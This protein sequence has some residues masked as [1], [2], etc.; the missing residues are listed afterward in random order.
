MANEFKTFTQRDIDDTS[1]TLY[2]C[3]S[4]TQTTIIGL[5]VAN[6]L[7]VSIT[8]SVELYDGGGNDPTHIVKDAIVPVGSSLVAVGGD[9]KIVMNAT[10]ILKVK[11]SQ[12]NCCDAIASVLEIT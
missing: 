10:D 11:G 3:P 5:N 6:I 9:Q 12:A 1:V 8:V 7:S 2:T 4:N